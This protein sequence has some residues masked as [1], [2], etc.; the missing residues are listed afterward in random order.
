[1]QGET[2]L[3]QWPDLIMAIY[4]EAK[5]LGNRSDVGVFE[6]VADEVGIALFWDHR[7]DYMLVVVS[8]LN[9]SIGASRFRAHVATVTRCVLV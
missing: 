3:E 1:L 4:Q 7:A 8:A 5:P 9:G 2:D 6:Y